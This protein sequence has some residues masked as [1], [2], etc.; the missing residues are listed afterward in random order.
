M[1][2]A[3]LFLT[4]I[5]KGSAHDDRI[6]IYETDDSRDLFRVVY[7]TPDYSN[8][9]TF[10]TTEHRVLDYIEDI[11]AGLRRDADPFEYI[12]VDSVIHPSIL[13]HVSDLDDTDVRELILGMIR[14]A[15][16]MDVENE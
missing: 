3:S 2:K 4:R 9:K 5:G 7:R 14:S 11:F 12:Q 1:Q 8:K 15:M 16:R 6:Y 10:T 13:F